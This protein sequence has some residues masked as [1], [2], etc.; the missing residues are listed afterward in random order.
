MMAATE[1]I[2]NVN[3][4]GC[5]AGNAGLSRIDESFGILSDWGLLINQ[6]CLSLCLPLGK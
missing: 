3:A 2:R 5:S 1:Q 6:L 4:V